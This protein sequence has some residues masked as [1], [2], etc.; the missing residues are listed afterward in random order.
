MEKKLD[1]LPGVHGSTKE[2]PPPQASPAL[3]V[4]PSF[5]LLSGV[6]QLY[7]SVAF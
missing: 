1:D 6:S 5:S 7:I 4:N 3:A 2:V